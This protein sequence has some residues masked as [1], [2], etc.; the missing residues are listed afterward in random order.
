MVTVGIFVTQVTRKSVMTLV[1]NNQ[2]GQTCIGFH[3][4]CLSYLPDSSKTHQYII[5]RKSVQQEQSCFIGQ[6]DRH[7]EA[8]SRCSPLHSKH[9]LSPSERANVVYGI[10]RCLLWE[11][12]YR[13]HTLFGGGG[14]GGGILD[15]EV[16]SNYRNHRHRKGWHN[17]SRTVQRCENFRLFH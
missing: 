9:T 4:K 6:T 14:G 2:C 17:C 16:G 12:L 11:L 7:G 13:K 3:V 10:Y 8:N 5:A 1:T 15:L